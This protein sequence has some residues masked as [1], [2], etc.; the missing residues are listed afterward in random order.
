MTDST[1]TS[2]QQLTTREMAKQASALRSEYSRIKQS[3]TSFDLTRGKPGQAQI[4]LS[5]AIDGILDGNYKL[6]NGSESGN[7]GGLLGIPEARALGAEILGAEPEQ[8]LAG[9]NSSLTLMALFVQAAHFFGIFADGDSWLEAASK[10]GEAVKFLCPVPGYDRHF[11]IC[12]SLSIEMIPTPMTDV[13]P[14][15]DFIRQAVRGDSMIKGIWCVPRYSNPTGI[16]YSPEVVEDLA[17]L[18]TIA[19]PNFIVLWDNAYAVHDLHDDEPT[20]A[21]LLSLA[22]SYNCSDQVAMFASTSKITLAGAGISWLATSTDT[23]ARFAKVQSTIS[24]GPDKVNQLR[25]VRFLPDLAAIKAHMKQHA[26]IVRPKF[27]AILNRL[28]QDLGGLGIA[29]WSKPRGGYFISFDCLPGHAKE[30][31]RLAAEAGVKFTPAGSTWPYG[32][33]PQDQNIRLAPTFPELAEVDAAMVVFTLCVKL[34]AAEK[35]A[36]A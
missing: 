17:K 35:L 36:Q 3:G 6:A 25:H 18:P 20:V 24:I 13:G 32:K 12:E 28:E 26:A 21:S 4:E 1:A 10:S 23:L 19:G 15:M 5:A 22:D 9:G 31:V 33:D 2:W 11:T 7:Y 30:V 16:C 29:S 34:V 27:E 14:D 8:V